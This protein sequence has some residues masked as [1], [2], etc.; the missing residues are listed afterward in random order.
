VAGVNGGNVSIYGKIDI[1]P[2]FAL[3]N[4]LRQMMPELS[5]VG[6]L[7]NPVLNQAMATKEEAEVERI[8]QMGAITV[9]V[10]GKV[11]DYLSGQ[12]AKQENLVDHHGEPVTI[13][14]VKRLIN[15]WL[16]EA[17]VENPKGAIFAQ[18]RDAGIPHSAGNAR[19]QIRL[20]QTIVF[21]LFPSEVGGGYFYDF[22][23]TWCLGYAS[24]EVLA[25]YEDVL[26]VYRQVMS[27][28]EAHTPCQTY[29]RRTC[30]LFEARGHSTICSSPQTREGYVH[31]LG[32]GLGL[33]VHEFP[34][35]GETATPDDRLDPGVVVTIE[36]GLYYP[37]RGLGVRLEDTVYVRPDGEMEV[38]ANYPLELVIPVP[39]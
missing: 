3:L 24:D 39:S 17:G 1:G 27:E 5:I 6:E 34:R 19:T 10:V 18:G 12:R 38:L 31:S 28:L 33:N 37:D 14:A 15:L 8:R 16:A 7:D 22:T 2:Y 36:P 26:A 21:D 25:V 35:F 4:H 13:G 20:G 32:H 29:Q 23:R 9:G 11:A 30:E